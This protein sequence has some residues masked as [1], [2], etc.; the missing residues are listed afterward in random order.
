MSSPPD[1]EVILYDLACTKNICFSPVVWRIRLLLN[2]KRIPYRTIFLEF[3]DIEPTLQNL[4]KNT[5][6]QSRQSTTPPPPPSSWTPSPSR[7]SSSQHTPARLTSPFSPVPDPALETRIRAASGPVLLRSIMPREIR[8]LCPRAAEYFRRSREAGL[9]GAKLE[10]V[11]EGEEERWEDAREGLRGLDEELKGIMAGGRF[12][13]GETPC[14]TD[15]FIAGSLQSARTVDEGV[16]RRAVVVESYK[17]IY[18][19]CLPWMER[20]D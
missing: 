10:D 9:N 5:P 14:M 7:T 2:Y 19:A 12:L 4:T 13:G 6:T 1:P 15:F 16:F 17:V 3:P 18:E 8:I 11:L 20:N